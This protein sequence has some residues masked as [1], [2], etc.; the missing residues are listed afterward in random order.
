MNDNLIKL[1]QQMNNP[2]VKEMQE[3]LDQSVNAL[4]QI[5]SKTVLNKDNVI[6]AISNQI[7]NIQKSLTVY[8]TNPTPQ[9][10]EYV[11][12]LFFPVELNLEYLDPKGS[13]HKDEANFNRFT[14]EL[15]QLSSQ[16][17]K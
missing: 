1:S 9:M 15:Q 2:K 11:K 14:Q 13:I 8:Q 4:K 5:E 3:K 10:L 12:S 7:S 6:K 17:P 16:L